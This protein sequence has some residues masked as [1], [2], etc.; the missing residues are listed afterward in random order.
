MLKFRYSIL[1]VLVLFLIGF[2]WLVLK[3]IEISWIVG[4]LILLGLFVFFNQ[5]KSDIQRFIDLLSLVGW[6]LTWMVE[7]IVLKGDIG[8]MNTVFKF[9]LQAWTLIAITSSCYALQLIPIA[10]RK[11]SGNGNKFG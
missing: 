7:V 8:R 5:S 6:G 2:S 3:G 4:P 1:F 11:W 9:Y 10:V